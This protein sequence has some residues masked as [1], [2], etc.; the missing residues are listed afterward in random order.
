MSVSRRF[1]KSW[2]VLTLSLGLLW[3]GAGQAAGLLTPADGHTPA[4]QIRDHAVN[5]IIEDGYAITR[6]EQ[7]FHNPHET[8]LEA[9]YSFPVPKHCAVAEF[10][11]WIDGRPVS[12]EVVEKQR[13]REIYQQEKQAGRDAGVTEKDD[14]RSFDIRVSPI[15]A[16]QDTRIRLVYLQPA[17]VD[18][19]IG[20]YVYPLAEGGV[21]AQKLAFWSSGP[22]VLGNFSFNLEVKSAYP[23]AAVRVPDQQDAQI[24]KRGDQNW[25]VHLSRSASATEGG[26]PLQSAFSLDKD[27]LVYWR[28]EDNL[29]GT[30]DM[31]AY[32]PEGRKQGT[33]MMVLTPGDDLQTIREGRDWIYVLDISGSM[34]D[35]YA[36]LA[37]GVTRALKKLNPNDRFR[38]V[39]FNNDAQELTA[40]WIVATPDNV[41]RYVQDV[42]NVQVGGG[43]NLYAGLGK[44]LGWLDADRTTGI[45]LV[46]DGVANVG[47]TAQKKFLELLGNK[48]VRLFT[49]IMGNS[50]NE[51]LL[52]ALTKAS[53]GF[54]LNV[55]NSDDMVGVILNAAGKVSHQALHGVELD[56]DG[57]KV[58]DLTPKPIGSLYR[59]Q[60]LVVFG[61]YSGDGDA[62]VTLSGK[63]S[64]RHK[65]YKTRFVFPKMAT[66]HPEIERLWAYATIEDEVDRINSFGENDDSRKLVTELGKEFG[67]VTDYTSMVV[68]REEQFEEYGI[69]RKN[70]DRLAREQ[71]AQ[72]QRA[73]QAAQSRRVDQ[74]QPMFT[75]SR[76]SFGGGSTDW[77]SLILLVWLAPLAAKNRKQS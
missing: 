42:E 62:N 43:T 20:R 7:V 67:L 19:G 66:E 31:V 11:L 1:L 35:K 8:D 61:H 65:E 28:H 54:A 47:E 38:V 6:V 53:N 68:L 29:P 48:D 23:V 12:G 76:P 55:S 22:Q 32:K 57:V 39:L 75:H 21:D 73:Q 14:H 49:F 36:A 16:G 37:D 71:L 30:V 5:V 45:V 17:R 44:G 2:Q 13:A 74:K 34:R 58:H 50:A 59:G 27:I 69:K 9:I 77:V 26:Q 25:A 40:G 41:S 52:R 64:G 33:F 46:T 10:T 24:S 3:T 60:Q 51:P 72:Q 18:T 4:L 70:R 63:I 15:R 56:I